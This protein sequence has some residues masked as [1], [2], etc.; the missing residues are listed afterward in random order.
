LLVNH[1]KARFYPSP[2]P[3][4]QIKTPVSFFI[5]I[6]RVF[7]RLS[8]FYLNLVPGGISTG[9]IFIHNMN[10]LCPALS[11]EPGFRFPVLHPADVSVTDGTEVY[12]YH[13]WQ[14]L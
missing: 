12:H 8:I 13:I 4:S 7:L 14:Y 2:D 3:V 1:R 6:F 10:S 9:M 11:H 5:T